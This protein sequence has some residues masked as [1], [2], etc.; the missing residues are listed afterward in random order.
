MQCGCI[1]K[2]AV[3]LKTI[4]SWGAATDGVAEPNLCLYWFAQMMMHYDADALLLS[5]WSIHPLLLM[6]D[7]LNPTCLADVLKGSKIVENLVPCHE[8]P[9]LHKIF[10]QV[11]LCCILAQTKVLKSHREKWKL[12]ILSHFCK[13]VETLLK[14]TQKRESDFLLYFVVWK[15][16]LPLTMFEFGRWKE[17][18]NWWQGGGYLQLQLL[19]M[20]NKEAGGW[21]FGELAGGLCWQWMWK[22]WAVIKQPIVAL[23]SAN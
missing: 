21:E 2:Q 19:T 9:H 14:K 7:L 10:L 20:N 12:T 3:E 18:G 13:R 8:H 6:H 23:F 4:F 16:W 17:M 1:I 11:I 15:F 5:L 22:Q